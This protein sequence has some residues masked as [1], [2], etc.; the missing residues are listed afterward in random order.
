MPCG[1][2][3]LDM[4]LLGVGIA[5]ATVMSGY[6]LADKLKRKKMDANFPRK[7]HWYRKEGYQ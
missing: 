7:T 5:L 4:L 2:S 1:D 3:M 6:L